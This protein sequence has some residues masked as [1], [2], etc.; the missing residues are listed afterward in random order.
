MLV[1][2]LEILTQK[3]LKKYEE[4]DGLVTHHFI[5]RLNKIYV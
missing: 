2:Y 4:C 3:M 1:L 5:L